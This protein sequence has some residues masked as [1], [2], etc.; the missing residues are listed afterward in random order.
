MSGYQF[1]RAGRPTQ[2]AIVSTQTVE[3]QLMGQGSG[4]P[5]HYVPAIFDPY[6]R[7]H[8]NGGQLSQPPTGRYTQGR[9]TRLR[10]AYGHAGPDGGIQPNIETSLN[11]G[12][13]AGSGRFQQQLCQ[14]AWRSDHSVGLSGQLMIVLALAF[15]EARADW[16]PAWITFSSASYSSTPGTPGMWVSAS[17]SGASRRVRAGGPAYALRLGNQDHYQLQEICNIDIL[18]FQVN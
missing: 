7:V 8:R 18:C 9:W 6:D 5:R 11:C 4:S 17:T 15:R 14:R 16:R 3:W 10:K 2:L 1:I 12:P 13:S